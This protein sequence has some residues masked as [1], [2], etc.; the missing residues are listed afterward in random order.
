MSNQ[1]PAEL[2]ARA[3]QAML[4]AYVP[5][6]HFSVGVCLRSVEGQFFTGCNIE[7]ASYGLTLCAEAGAMAAMICGGSKKWLEALI[8]SSGKDFCSPC[9]ACR[10]RLFEFAESTSIYHLCTLSGD[11]R[12]LT[13]EELFPY[14]FGNFNLTT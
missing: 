13:M 12:I 2:L 9:G 14:P 11:Y 7:N 6:S 10:Q 3:K 1:P 8:I 5:Y 4:R